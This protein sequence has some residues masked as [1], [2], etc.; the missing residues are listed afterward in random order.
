[1]QNVPPGHRRRNKHYD[2]EGHAHYLTFS[3]FRRQPFLARDRTRWWF[4]DALAD[5]RTKRP[6]CLWAWVIMPE[7]VHILLRPHEG[8]TI[9]R[10]LQ[11]IKQPV[12]RKAVA[13]VRQRSPRFL[14]RM[15]DEQPSGR[16]SHRFWQRGGGYD[17]N[18][19]SPEELR[20]KIAYIHANPVRRGLV[21][22]PSEWPW[23]SWNP[24]NKGDE[25]LSP[26]T[27]DRESFPTL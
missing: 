22:H 6:F 11:A 19:W 2:T 24:W 18:I 12:S 23:S 15:A 3:C 7:H 5:A 16:T 27:V 20:E 9:G 26:L 8:V 13:W 14:A 4:V 1:M 10:I 21:T 17:R 25:G